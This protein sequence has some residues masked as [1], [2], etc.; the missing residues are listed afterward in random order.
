M[1]PRERARI[2]AACKQHPRWLWRAPDGTLYRWNEI[3]DSLSASTG[4]GG[5]ADAEGAEEHTTLR[6]RLRARGCTIR[7]LKGSRCV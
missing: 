4:S 2:V 3:D 6:E 7:S 1:S 5:L